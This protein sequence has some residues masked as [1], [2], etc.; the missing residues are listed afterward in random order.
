[1]AGDVILISEVLVVSAVWLA[2]SFFLWGAGRLVRRMFRSDAEKSDPFFDWWIGWALTVAVL[3]AWHFVFAMTVWAFIPIA[4]AGAAGAWVARSDLKQAFRSALAAPASVTALVVLAWLAIAA[5]TLRPDSNYDTALYHLPTVR[6]AQAYPVVPGLAN[7]AS[8]FGMNSSFF[9]FCGLVERLSIHGRD[10]RL[11]AGLPFLPLIIQGIVTAHFAVTRTQKMDLLRWFQV[12]MIPITIWQ[13]RRYASSMSPD[14]IVFVLTV[15]T[16]AELLRI[17]SSNEEASD[18]KVTGADLDYRVFGLVLLGIIG[19]TVKV[20]F[21][22]FGVAAAVMALW[23]WWALASEIPGSPGSSRSQRSARLASVIGPG[24][25]LAA[26]W[27]AHGVILSGYIAYP[28]TFG[29]FPTDWRLAPS[30]LQSDADWIASWARS[31]GADPRRVLVTYDWVRGWLATIARDRNVIGMVFTFAVAAAARIAFRRRQPEW[32][33]PVPHRASLFLLPSLIFCGVWLVTA[34][35][36]R[37]ALGPLWVI[38]VGTLALSFARARDAPLNERRIRMATHALLAVMLGTAF[39][40]ALSE[41]AWSA[42]SY[43]IQPVKTDSGL[44]VYLPLTGDQC[45]DA[46][47]PCSSNPPNPRLELRRPGSLA[48]GFRIAK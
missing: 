14:G 47:L 46:P 13:A 6:W 31:P 8:R 16:T 40:L 7:L 29:S 18:P 17:L 38:A 5:L 25:A 41:S 1:M 20:S 19:M 10:L 44:I 30:V 34:P 43:P 45:G 37:L 3:I 42:P 35:A 36:I 11:A 24:I 21:V 33:N 27:M 39:T 48:S 22:F 12:L 23:R 26:L 28:S 9:L 32:T 15:V 2:L 4:V